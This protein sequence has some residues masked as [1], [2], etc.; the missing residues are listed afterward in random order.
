MK[1]HLPVTG[2][3]YTLPPGVTLMSTTD[4][5][6]RIRY[7][8]AAFVE[9]SGFSHKELTGQPHNMVRHPDMPPQAFADMWKTLQDG[10][11]WAAV[12][13]NRRK[14][15]DHYWVLANAT[16]MRRN[17]QVV[18]YMSVRTPASPQQAQQAERL[19]ADLREGRANGRRIHRGLVVQSG[20][21]APLSLFQLMPLRARVALGV[22]LGGAVA[23]LPALLSAASPLQL[24]GTAAAWAGG[25]ALGSLFLGRQV[26]KPVQTMLHH[27]NQ[28]ASGEA[29]PALAMNRVDEIGLLMRAINQAGLNLRALVDD[30]A[31]QVGGVAVASRQIASGSSDLSGRTEQTAASLQQTAASMEQMTQTVQQNSATSA[32][33]RTLAE[34]ASEAASLGGSVMHQVREQMNDIQDHGTRIAD[35]IGVIDG[36]AFQTNILAL[37]AAVEAARAGEA[38]RGFAVVAGEVR[39]LAQRSATAAREI[40]TLI[41]E[42]VQ[43]VDAGNRH[44]EQAGQ[45][46]QQIIDRVRQVTALVAEIS[47]ASQQQGQGVE[48]VHQAIAALDG[49]T[50]HNAALVEQS[51]AAAQSLDHRARRLSDAIN[52]Y[53]TAG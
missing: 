53:R 25:V 48:Q 23:A 50:Q 13:K 38:G 5:D 44:V 52:V 41:Q 45:T 35:I 46:I 49:T 21:R 30:V 3:E 26:V 27:A 6:S 7:A 24:L 31:E 1:T 8:N 34:Q 51:A 37:N 20:W 18:G 33:A 9:A 17:G 43:R 36:I 4:L 39:A 14:D 10:L 42:S 32:Q 15:G 12:V 2:R 16:P 29:A 22:G 40:K 11:S 28:V 47:Q 19:Y